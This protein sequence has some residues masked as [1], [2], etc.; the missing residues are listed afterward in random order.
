MADVTA[1]W[2]EMYLFPIVATHSSIG[3]NVLFQNDGNIF[4]VVSSSVNSNSQA[5]D[6]VNKSGAHTKISLDVH[7]I[8]VLPL[9]V[10]YNVHSETAISLQASRKNTQGHVL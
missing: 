7:V 8:A 2:A 10:T 5:D 4:I 3:C 6:S 1:L 9:L